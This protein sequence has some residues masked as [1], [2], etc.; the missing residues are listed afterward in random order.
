MSSCFFLLSDE[1]FISVINKIRLIKVNRYEQA[2]LYW[3]T[4]FINENSSGGAM[5]DFN[6]HIK[7]VFAFDAN[8][9]DSVSNYRK[10]NNDHSPLFIIFLLSIYKIVGDV[11]ILRFVFLHFSLLIPLLFCLHWL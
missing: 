10:F 9:I 2:K 5:Q 3:P 7:I 11:D 1:I 4:R 8:F 6:H